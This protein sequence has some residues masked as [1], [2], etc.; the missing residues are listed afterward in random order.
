MSLEE[1]LDRI[2]LFFRLPVVRY[3]P[4]AEVAREGVGAWYWLCVATWP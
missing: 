3:D 4:V 2:A 1:R